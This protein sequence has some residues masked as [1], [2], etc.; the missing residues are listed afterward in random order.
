MRAANKVC[1]GQRPTIRSKTTRGKTARALAVALCSQYMKTNTK[2]LLVGSLVAL[3]GPALA[4]FFININEYSLLLSVVLFGSVAAAGLV[5][6]S[7]SESHKVAS[8]IVPAFPFAAGVVLVNTVHYLL[9][10]PT[11]TPGWY[12]AGIIVTVFL[13]I[14]IA[15][16]VAGGV[17]GWLVTRSEHNNAFK[18]DVAKATRP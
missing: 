8:A 1:A 6:A 18:S 12:G 13:P 14:G 5:T 10:Y 16:S 11:D 15:L 17:V 2:S 4:A 3:I 7:I 9:G